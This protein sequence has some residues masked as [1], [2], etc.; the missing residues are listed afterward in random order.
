MKAPLPCPATPGA[1]RFRIVSLGAR[2]LIARRTRSA[3]R[4]SRG[5]ACLRPVGAANGPSNSVVNGTRSRQRL[6]VFGAILLLSTGC[7]VATSAPAE[8]NELDAAPS[9]TEALVQVQVHQPLDAAGEGDVLTTIVRS[10]RGTDPEELLS[11]AGL[12]PDVPLVGSCSSGEPASDGTADEAALLSGIELVFADRVVLGTPSG[13]EVLVPHAFPEVFS[14][15]GGVVF[16]SRDRSGSTLVPG[17]QYRVRIENGE[18]FGTVVTSHEAPSLPSDVTVDGAPLL[19]GQAL[20]RSAVVSWKPSASA[21]DIVLLELSAGET[22]VTCAYDDASGHGF[23]ALDSA[24]APVTPGASAT[25]SVHRLRTEAVVGA[26]DDIVVEARFDYSV[27]APVT[28][29]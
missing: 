15:L 26:S 10:A 22:H 23:F 17:E 5:E 27:S 13:E 18:G 16:A 25:F 19:A 3:R 24:V 4:G 2:L 12:R 14:G 20:A 7:T 8:G 29:E 1:L 28:L 9:L 11:V 21:H 6:A